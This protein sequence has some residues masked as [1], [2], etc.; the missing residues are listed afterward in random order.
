MSKREEQ[1][2]AAGKQYNNSGL[3]PGIEKWYQDEWSVKQE[4]LTKLENRLG[5]LMVK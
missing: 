2:P 4:K 5:L 3:G 1:K